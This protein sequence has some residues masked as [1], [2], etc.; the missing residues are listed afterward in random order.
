MTH[1]PEQLG[2]LVVGI[3]KELKAKTEKSLKAYGIGMGQLQILMLFYA[4]QSS[5][6]SQNE[7][8]KLLNIDKGNISRNVKKLMD[9]AY[10]EQV[11]EH[12]KMYQLSAQGKMIKREIMTTFMSLHQTMTEGVSKEALTQTVMIL[13]KISVNLEAL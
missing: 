10:L 2:D 12:S 1:S 8:V 5:S 11:P 9:K 13:S 7:L 6:Y 3:Y 4:H